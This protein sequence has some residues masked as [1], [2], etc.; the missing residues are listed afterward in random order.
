M[1]SWWKRTAAATLVA[2]PP[3]ST[4]DEALG[5]FLKVSWILRAFTQVSME[6]CVNKLEQITQLTK[7]SIDL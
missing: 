5:N 3:S 6:R 1:L 2:E 7:L 4:L